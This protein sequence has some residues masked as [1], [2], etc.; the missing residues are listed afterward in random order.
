[1]SSGGRP[2]GGTLS[3]RSRYQTTLLTRF[4]RRLPMDALDCIPAPPLGA[5]AAPALAG[6]YSIIDLGNLG[7]PTACAVGIN[8][9]GQVAGTSYLAEHVEYKGVS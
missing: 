3:P 2:V 4:I 5:A 1:M 6:P 8:E 9:S 7:Y